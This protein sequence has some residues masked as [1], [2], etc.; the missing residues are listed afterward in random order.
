MLQAVLIGSFSAYQRK[1]GRQTEYQRP[2]FW[3]FQCGSLQ[4]FCTIAAD[5]VRSPGGV[6]EELEQPVSIAA[7]AS[8]KIADRTGTLLY[9]ESRSRPGRHRRRAGR[10][11]VTAPRNCGDCKANPR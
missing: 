2:R 3:S 10:R 7:N 6:G 8:I 5:S 1:D 4:F 11:R 9:T